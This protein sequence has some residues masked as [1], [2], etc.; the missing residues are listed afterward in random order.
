[1]PFN[2]NLFLDGL[3]E[4]GL[5]TGAWRGMLYD[6]LP[7]PEQEMLAALVVWMRAE[8]AKEPKPAKPLKLKRRRAP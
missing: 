7:Q 8:F 2:Y 5:L 6:E 4:A 3:E 1:M